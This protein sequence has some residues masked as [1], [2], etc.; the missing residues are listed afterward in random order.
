[1][2]ST[3]LITDPHMATTA[4]TNKNTNS[5]N[6]IS[7]ITVSSLC[8]SPVLVTTAPYAIP[9]TGLFFLP[10]NTPSI[11]TNI[12]TSLY[13]SPTRV[14]LLVLLSPRTHLKLFLAP[15]CS[16]LHSIAI[17]LTSQHDSLSASQC[18]HHSPLIPVT[19]H[20][21]LTNHSYIFNDSAGESGICLTKYQDVRSLAGMTAR[22]AMDDK[23]EVEVTM[24]ICAWC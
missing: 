18:R 11:P 20:A 21:P 9:H 5:N 2:T 16:L 1:M 7:T 19:L 24:Y 6:N 22:Q 4:A 14:S 12:I 15:A 13:N 17:I 3:S 23:G 10:Y 8:E